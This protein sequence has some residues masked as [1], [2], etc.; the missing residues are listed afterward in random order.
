MSSDKGLIGGA[1]WIEFEKFSDPQG[2][3][4]PVEGERHVPFPIKRVFFFYDVPVGSRRGAHAHREQ[5]QVLACLAGGFDVDLNDGIRR[6]VVHVARPWRGLYLPPLLWTDQLNFDGGT[7]G[8]V[9]ASDLFD[10][11][12]YI[13]D[14]EEYRELAA[15]R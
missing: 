10:E 15:Q 13:R 6:Q 2:S 1:K 14:F 5:H 11:G 3:L 12:D 7:V 8:L 4:T 9:L